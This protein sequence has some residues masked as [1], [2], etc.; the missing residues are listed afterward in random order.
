MIWIIIYRKKSLTD[1]SWIHLFPPSR[2]PVSFQKSVFLNLGWM[3]ND[4]LVEK[5]WNSCRVLARCLAR[6][7]ERMQYSCR[8]LPRSCKNRFILTSFFQDFNVSYKIL[9][10]I[11]FSSECFF[12]AQNL[13]ET[14]LSFPLQN[15]S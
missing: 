12:I 9:A 15:C 1:N 10:R 14:F 8:N 6:S 3:C 13:S 7:C 11:S 5:K 4:V 2:K